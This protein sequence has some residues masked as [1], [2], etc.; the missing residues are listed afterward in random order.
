MPIGKEI[1]MQYNAPQ[2]VVSMG[3]SFKKK[4]INIILGKV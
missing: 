3:F 2:N 4:I 1:H